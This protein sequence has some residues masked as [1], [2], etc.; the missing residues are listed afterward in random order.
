[1][2]V[3]LVYYGVV[4]SDCKFRLA[5]I[6]IDQTQQVMGVDIIRYARYNLLTY[7]CCCLQLAILNQRDC[8]GKH[9]LDLT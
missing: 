9:H 4:S 7:V 2:I 1:M 5:G 3:R 6:L 8:S